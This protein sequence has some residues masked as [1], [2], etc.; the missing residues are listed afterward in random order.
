M[1]YAIMHYTLSVQSL[2]E[3]FKGFPFLETLADFPE[4]ENEW[5]RQAAVPGMADKFFLN[6]IF[7][8]PLH[9]QK[10]PLVLKYFRI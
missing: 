2:K 6:C 9:L 3:V 4:A 7:G 5:R 10:M 8:R 1:H